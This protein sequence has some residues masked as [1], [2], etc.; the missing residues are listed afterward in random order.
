MGSGKMMSRKQRGGEDETL[1]GEIRKV[2]PGNMTD[3]R[4]SDLRICSDKL[5]A[6]TR[7]IIVLTSHLS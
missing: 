7:Q 4:R 1:K 2:S 6:H 3:D 5:F